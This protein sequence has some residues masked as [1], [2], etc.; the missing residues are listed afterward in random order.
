MDDSTVTAGAAVFSAL[1]RCVTPRSATKRAKKPTRFPT[2][3]VTNPITRQ[4]LCEI[5]LL[6][7]GRVQCG[8][9][10]AYKKWFAALILARHPL[11]VG[12]RE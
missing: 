7:L 5:K 6:A 4:P 9:S 3:L 11:S 10:C 2:R 1:F 8:F 12:N